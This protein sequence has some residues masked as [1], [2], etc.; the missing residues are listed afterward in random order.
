MDP[1]S[2]TAVSS[3]VFFYLIFPRLGAGKTSSLKTLMAEITEAKKSWLSQAKELP[4]GNCQTP[5]IKTGPQPS[6][7]L[8]P[9]GEPR[10]SP[11]LNS[12]EAAPGPLQGWWQRS[13]SG[14]L[15]LHPCPVISSPHPCGISGGHTGSQPTPLYLPTILMV[16][17]RPMFFRE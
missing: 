6:R 10:L 5:W 11:L 8:A 17:M 2:N 14:E 16:S 4:H 9:G 12:H 1:N 13:L 15:G 3:C 7:Q